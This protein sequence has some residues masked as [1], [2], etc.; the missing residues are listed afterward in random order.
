MVTLRMSKLMLWVEAFQLK[1]PDFF[2]FL[3][4]LGHH[5]PVAVLFRVS[6]NTA[7]C[8]AGDAEKLDWFRPRVHRP[9]LW[10]AWS[11]STHVRL[12]P[13]PPLSRSVLHSPCASFSVA[14]VEVT[15]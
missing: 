3:N 7:N 13:N 1:Y 5:L 15:A 2:T 12:T 9:D 10:A 6:G 4:S 11:V 14:Y 8:P